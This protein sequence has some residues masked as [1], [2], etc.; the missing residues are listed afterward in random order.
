[1]IIKP[2]ITRLRDAVATCGGFGRPE[3]WQ[4]KSMVYPNYSYVCAKHLHQKQN[5]RLNWSN[6]C[7][8]I[9]QGIKHVYVD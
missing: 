1:M 7:G 8:Q 6:K 5:V 3:N 2:V 9:L 4:F